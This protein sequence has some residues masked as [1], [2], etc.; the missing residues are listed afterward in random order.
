MVDVPLVVIGFF[1]LV[2]M[3]PVLMAVAHYY[4][5]FAQDKTAWYVVMLDPRVKSVDHV[6]EDQ[7]RRYKLKVI[8][9]FNGL[10]KGYTA[11]VPLKNVERLKSDRRVQHL[12]RQEQEDEFASA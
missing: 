8:K 1:A 7:A 2:L 4:A 3:P 5:V 12:E 6:A 9:T 11:I 10:V